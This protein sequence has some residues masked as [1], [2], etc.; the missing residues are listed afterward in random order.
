MVRSLH[1]SP[2]FEKK[3]ETKNKNTHWENRTK[4]NKKINYSGR[5]KT[6]DKRKMYLEFFAFAELLKPFVK[7]TAGYRKNTGQLQAPLATRC[8]VGQE[9]LKSGQNIQN[10]NTTYQAKY[11]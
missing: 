4:Q 3:T 8:T 2:T 11:E 1:I 9:A 6:L 7:I 5:V 10:G